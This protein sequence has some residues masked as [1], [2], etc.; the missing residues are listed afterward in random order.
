MPSRPII[1]LERD[2]FP[3][4]QNAGTVTGPTAGATVV[5]LT[6]TREGLYELDVERFLTG[7]GQGISDT[8]NMQL[9]RNSTVIMSPL[10][11]LSTSGAPFEDQYSVN[12]A[13]NDVIAV[14]VIAN[15]TGTVIYCCSI[16]ARLI[17]TNP[18][19]LVELYPA[20]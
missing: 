1:N 9:L 6:I 13:K 12:C 4:L 19:A 3:T 5:S 14:K 15:G 16:I 2:R 18:G 10:L 8:N 7:T 11:T 17:C 20:I